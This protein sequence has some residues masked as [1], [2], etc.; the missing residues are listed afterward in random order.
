MLKVMTVVKNVFPLSYF[1][2]GKVLVAIC[3][4]T[5]VL[6]AAIPPIVDSKLGGQG[7]GLASPVSSRKICFYVRMGY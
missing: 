6:A 3:F 7:T 5:N 4:P 1:R 2:G